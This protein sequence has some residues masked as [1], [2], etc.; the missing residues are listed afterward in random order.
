MTVRYFTHLPPRIC[1]LPI[2]GWFVAV[3]P[4]LVVAVTVDFFIPTVLRSFP[5]VTRFL[6]RWFH[7]LL[8]YDY[9][10]T[11]VYLDVTHFDLRLL[12]TP[13]L[14]AF[15]WLRTFDLLHTVYNLL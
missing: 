5:T 1:L 6:L 4:R 11:T 10:H 13:A 14:R 8:D 15:V 3:V 2:Y 12:Y 7:D 9:P